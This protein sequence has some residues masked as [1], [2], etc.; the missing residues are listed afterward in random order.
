MARGI[1]YD[2]PYAGALFCPSDGTSDA[3]T[4][5]RVTGPQWGTWG[6]SHKGSQV[7]LWYNRR[8]MPCP[9]GDLLVGQKEE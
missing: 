4:V 6:A 7:T 1:F 5:G 9:F 8:A 3:E 2:C